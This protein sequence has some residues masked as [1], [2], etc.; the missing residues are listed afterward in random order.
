MN[1]DQLLHLFQQ[2]HKEL[3]G[4]ASRSVDICLVTR[5]W[6]FGFYIVEYEQKGEDRAQYGENLF[7]NLSDKLNGKGIKGASVT[8]LRLS[9]LFYE[10]YSHFISRQTETSLP[11][12]L[13]IDKHLKIH[14]TLSDELKCFKNLNFL[15]QKISF[16]LLRKV[17]ENES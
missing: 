15:L 10:N 3:Q 13:L 7:K 6:L 2:T 1:F 5:N 12:N 8:S 16:T 14:Q 17:E 11:A 4:R 9:R